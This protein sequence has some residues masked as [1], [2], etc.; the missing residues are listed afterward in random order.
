[1]WTEAHAVKLT[2][3]Q[4]LSDRGPELVACLDFP[5]A[6]AAAGFADL[7]GGI[8]VDACFLHL[9]QAEAGPLPECVEQW[10][11]EFAATGRPVRAVLGYCAGAVLAARLADALAAR[12][13]PPILVLFD[14]IP[15]TAWLLA[16][17]FLAAVES[18][19]RHLTADEL[20]AAHDLADHVVATDPHDLP[21]I[22]A[23]LTGWYDK[24]MRAVADRLSLSEFLHRQLAEGF[25]AYFDYLLLAGE[26][27]FDLP[28]ATAMFV[29]SNGLEPPLESTRTIA[30]DVGHDELLREPKVHQL[31]ADLIRGEMPW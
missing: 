3:W 23:V 14:A 30:L 28:A 18:S 22:A 24:L 11:D 27:G 9:R 1:M 2:N 10:A 7:A 26:G 12:G 19:G 29:T 25:T 17:E 6:R 16:G 21:R 13:T 5:G 20:A 8:P 31:V 4:I 15:A